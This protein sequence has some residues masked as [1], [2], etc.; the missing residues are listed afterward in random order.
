PKAT[1]NLV[2]S[3]NLSKQILRSVVRR[4]A[5]GRSRTLIDQFEEIRGRGR[6]GTRLKE[7]CA[8]RMNR[9]LRHFSGSRKTLATSASRIV[10]LVQL[11]HDS[12]GAAR[13][14]GFPE[15]S[16]AAGVKEGIT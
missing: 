3:P 9:G 11:R 10:A 15:Q 1:A 12:G 14:T 16:P 4:V 2:R 13:T 6:G 8:S 7:I 5:S